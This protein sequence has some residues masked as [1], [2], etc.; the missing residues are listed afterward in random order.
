MWNIADST[1]T[2]YGNSY[3]NHIKPRIGSIP[4]K[5]LTASQIQAT[6]ESC[7]IPEAE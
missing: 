3:G 6:F 7:I 5:R 1:R 4:I 2:R